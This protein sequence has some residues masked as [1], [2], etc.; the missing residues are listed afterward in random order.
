MYIETINGPEDVKKLTL[1]QLPVL[2][3]EM[4]QSLVETLSLLSMTMI[5]RLPRITADCIRI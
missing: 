1:E 2:A 4:R 5:C 3:E